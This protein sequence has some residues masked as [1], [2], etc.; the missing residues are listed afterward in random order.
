MMNIF[1]YKCK[2]CTAQKGFKWVEN[3]NSGF[4]S[5]HSVIFNIYCDN[6][7]CNA[8]LYEN[9]QTSP[10]VTVNIIKKDKKEKELQI[11]PTAAHNQSKSYV[12]YGLLQN[13]I[14]IHHGSQ[15]AEMET[16]SDIYDL[17]QY[18]PSTMARDK[19]AAAKIMQFWG[20]KAVKE[21]QKEEEQYIKNCSDQSVRAR[22]SF[23][24]AY[25][26]VGHHDAKIGYMYDICA[27]IEKIT[28][29]EVE[30]LLQKDF[31]LDPE[32]YG[33]KQMEHKL[34]EKMVKRLV[35]WLAAIARKYEKK[36]EGEI[37]GDNDIKWTTIVEELDKL[38][39]SVVLT[40]LDDINHTFKVVYKLVTQARSNVPE[41]MRRGCGLDKVLAEHIYRGL[42]IGLIA[43]PNTY[44]QK[45]AIAIPDHYWNGQNH[46]TCPDP[47]CPKK[48][49]SEH[50]TA[51]NGGLY[52]DRND[53]HVHKR[54]YEE[55]MK[56]FKEYFSEERI[57]R[58]HGVPRT[59]PNET[60][61]SV[62]TRRSNKAT[63]PP[64]K[65]VARGIVASVAGTWNWG[66]GE[67]MFCICKSFGRVSNQ[68]KL[69][70]NQSQSRVIYNWYRSR[71][72]EH[73][74]K[75]AAKTKKFKKRQQK[76]D[77]N[78]VKLS[79]KKN[80]D[81]PKAAKRK[82]NPTATDTT[83]EPTTKRQ[84]T[85]YVCKRCGKY[86]TYKASYEKHVADDFQICK[87]NDKHV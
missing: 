70:L 67:W 5:G 54:T 26:A 52:F 48:K 14:L 69:K 18:S 71:S 55:F 85:T 34:G 8:L 33:S 22:H 16:M 68:H 43:N 31:T 75:Q 50:V 30:S 82:T 62:T 56:L 74:I 2:Q 44:S 57:K 51:I 45:D 63:R 40:K 28:G 25:F 46:V 9:Y 19:T 53:N 87:R 64:N 78:K 21:A 13:I 38:Y 10:R 20:D 23:D 41:K 1:A 83:T 80:T 7:D 66:F 35:K 65:E 81:K 15:N 12:L 24:G 11:Q 77:K 6:P 84:K 37:V 72:D 49:N 42:Q 86:Y 61:H 32:E 4:K 47:W 59:N 29:F 17:P 79:Y 73:K 58:L 36:V 3:N 27:A 39:D 60:A 76:R